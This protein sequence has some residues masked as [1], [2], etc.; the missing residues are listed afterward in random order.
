MAL[1][2][3]ARAGLHI[4]HM[5]I[6]PKEGAPPEQ[7]YRWRVT[8]ASVLGG[9][10]L[11]MIT[12]IAWAAGFLTFAGLQGFAPAQEVKDQAAVLV[13][14]KLGQLDSQILDI[15]SRQCK[16]IK[17]GNED[18]KAFATEKLQDALGRFRS[19]TGTDYRLPGCDEL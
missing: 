19:L 12:S 14:I 5:L 3:A 18:A 16:A 6:P 4:G 10:V 17:T 11:T 1:S 8:M 7:A 15:R 2:D 13:S 9:T